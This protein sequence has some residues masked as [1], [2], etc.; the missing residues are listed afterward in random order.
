MSTVTPAGVDFERC[1]NSFDFRTSPGAEKIAGFSAQGGPG[2]AKSA[3]TELLP[4]CSGPVVP[5]AGAIFK[6]NR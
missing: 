5:R 4:V 1:R 3:M 6:K 2:G